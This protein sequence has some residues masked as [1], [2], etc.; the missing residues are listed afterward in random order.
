MNP[1]YK[2]QLE[3]YIRL[4]IEDQSIWMQR[5]QYLPFAPVE[6]TVIRLSDESEEPNQIDLT[7]NSA[8]WDM[9]AG[10]FVC[11]VADETQVEAY[12]ESG[13]MMISE[14]VDTYKSYGFLRM[15]F[16]QVQVSR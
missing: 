8:V 3:V 5:I 9:A 15:N 6:G 4:P 13:H 11:Q 1:S 16:P 12:T 10:M 14:T 2:T 7:L